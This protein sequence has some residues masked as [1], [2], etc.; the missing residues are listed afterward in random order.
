MTYNTSSPGY[1]YSYSYS[2]EYPDNPSQN[3]SYA[4]G[5]QGYNYAPRFYMLAGKTFQV[6]PPVYNYTGQGCDGSV[7]QALSSGALM[8][9]LGDGSVKGVAGGVTPATWNAALTPTGG[10]V[11]GSDW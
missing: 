5:S 4:G 6:R 11:L 3:Y 9:L 7:P 2:I 10:E 8:V 1:T